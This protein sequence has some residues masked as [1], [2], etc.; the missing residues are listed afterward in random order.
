M[1]KDFDMESKYH[2]YMGKPQAVKNQDYYKL[3]HND[4][5]KKNRKDVFVHIDNIGAEEGRGM[6]SRANPND[7]EMRYSQ[8]NWIPVNDHICPPP[9]PEEFV[10]SI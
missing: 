3:K 7:Q 2:Q 10:R 1:I 8:T 5:M 6:L 4:I 9:I